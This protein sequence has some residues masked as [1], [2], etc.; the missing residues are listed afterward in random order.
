[1][2]GVRKH[3]QTRGAW[4]HAPPEKFWNLQSLR[5]LLVASETLYPTNKHKIIYCPVFTVS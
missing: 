5:L 1:M 4:G 3:A 2:Y